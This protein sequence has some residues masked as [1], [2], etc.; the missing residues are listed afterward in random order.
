MSRDGWSRGYTSKALTQVGITPDLLQRRYKI[1][2]GGI[3]PAHVEEL[4]AALA[5]ADRLGQESAWGKEL[6]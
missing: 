4:K 5:A 3:E 2:A 6:P 1:M